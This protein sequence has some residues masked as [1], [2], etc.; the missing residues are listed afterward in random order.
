MLFRNVPDVSLPALPI[1]GRA[2][3]E[4]FVPD[5]LPVSQAICVPSA[6]QCTCG[7]SGA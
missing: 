3:S 4:C 2:G 6:V 5:Q 1:D 7:K